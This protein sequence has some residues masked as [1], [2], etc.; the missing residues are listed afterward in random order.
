MKETLKLF[1]ELT[2][3]YDKKIKMI[4]IYNMKE[5]N[6]ISYMLLVEK[7]YDI[8]KKEDHIIKLIYKKLDL[9]INEFISNK[10]I[11]EASFILKN[12]H[13]E[14]NRLKKNVEDDIK[15][16]SIVKKCQKILG[17]YK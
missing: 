1:G 7:L 5:S 9:D 8:S 15:V 4:N 11:N 2:K 10:E 3:I 16:T 14:F 6:N 13:D 17:I 12:Q